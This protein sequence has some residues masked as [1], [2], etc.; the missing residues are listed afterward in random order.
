MHGDEQGRCQAASVAG[1]PA[2]AQHVTEIGY[3]A[4]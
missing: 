2:Y 3:D 4:E 1:L